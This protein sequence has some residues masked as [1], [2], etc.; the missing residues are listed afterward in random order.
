MDSVAARQFVELE[1][2]H[3][4]FEGRRRIF[5]HLLDQALIGRMDVRSLDVG[6]GA[7]GMMVE[8][9]RYGTPYGIDVDTTLLHVCRARGF[10]ELLNASGTHVPFMDASFDLVTLFDC[11]EHIDDDGMALCEAHRVLK[12][13]GLLFVSVPAYQFLYAH[14]DQVAHH[15]RRYTLSE[16]R[17]KIRLAG[18]GVIKASYI[19][20]L[21][22]PLILPAVLLI[23]LKERV[24]GDDG[25]RTNLSYTY[26]RWLNHALAA[27]FA[28]ERHLVSRW[29]VPGGH[30]ICRLAVRPVE[31]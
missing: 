1:R 3:W 19:N 20:A 12:P 28:A 8:L 21:L 18:F 10:Q 14:N 11:I 22:F 29:T 16:L 31:T 23:K 15:V 24:I 5:F 13:G 6:C 25:R 26:P 17:S 4:W 30:S 7:G 9:E 2:T 27:I